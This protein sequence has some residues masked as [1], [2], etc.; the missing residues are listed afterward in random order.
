MVRGEIR[1]RHGRTIKVPIQKYEQN[2]V[3]N[4]SKVAKYKKKVAKNKATKQ[5]VKKHREKKKTNLEEKKINK[6]DNK[7]KK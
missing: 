6:K 7:K 4:A 5:R 2:C 3:M 1:T